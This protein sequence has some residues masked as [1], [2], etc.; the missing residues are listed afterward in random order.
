[1][2]TTKNAA[3]VLTS[4]VILLLSGVIISLGLGRLLGPELYGRYG[5][6]FAVASVLNVLLTPGIVQAIAKHI[7]EKKSHAGMVAKAMLKRQLIICTAL[8][9]IYFALATPL[10]QAMNDK[11]LAWLLRAITPMAIL[12]GI[13]AVYGGYLT[14]LG[15]FAEQ[16][17]Q[18]IIYSTSR[19]ALTFT[20][21]YFFSVTGALA[22]L[23]LASLMA[24][25]YLAHTAKLKSD[26]RTTPTAGIYKLAMP[27]TMFTAL[28]TLF[29][30]TD[31]LL[32][33]ALLKSPEATG[34][35]TAASTIARMPYFVLTALATL[36]LPAVAEKL[37]SSK[38]EAQKFVRETI[39]YVLMLLLPATALLVSTAKPLVMLLYRSE[40]VHA[41]EPTAILAAG[42]A[43]LTT[44]Y[45]LATVLNAAGKTSY[46]LTV[47]AATLAASVAANTMA[48]PQYGLKGAAAVVAIASVA[49]AIA[50][51]LGA[52]R[53]IGNFI[54]YR[55][56]AKTAAAS[57][58]ILALAMSFRLQNKF[59]L[60]VEYAILGV[61]YLALLI[62]LKEINH[63]DK[64]RLRSLIP[65]ALKKA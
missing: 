65:N 48:I 9:I 31:L 55:S 1:M 8:A 7:A 12:Y 45:L 38:E 44:A 51:L 61:L 18:L 56:I 33:H 17:I 5:I 46:P 28:I 25:L 24:L 6:V 11:S 2:S 64:E 4:Q 60:P 36:M 20:L 10:A 32:V 14:G 41:A 63:S 34:Y 49:A 43:A 15:R 54:P 59:L 50:M 53:R 13:S 23:P 30:N 3:Y 21:A 26:E 58:A 29:M 27:L 42:T 57:L 39:R 40:Y 22:A 62:A 16:S 37:A 19:L 47:M 35:Y 52:Y